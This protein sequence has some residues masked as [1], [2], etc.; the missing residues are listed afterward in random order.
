MR[1]HKQHV[2]IIGAGMGGLASALRLAYAGLRVTVL[3]RLS[4][5]GGKMR[6]LPSVAG[7]VDAGPTVLTM[8]GVFDALFA[9]TG[10]PLEDHVTL[11]REPLLARHFWK[12]GPTLDLMADPDHSIQ[13]VGDAFGM[14]AADEFKAFS[15]KAKALF[16][17]FDAPVMRAPAP[18]N[19]AITQQMLRTPS[20]LAAMSP[21]LSLSGMLKRQFTDPRLA[22]LFG[23]YATYVGGIPDASPALLSLIWHAEAQ[24]VWHVVGGMHRL[25]QAICA[26]AQEFGAEFAF[27]THVKRIEV[28]EGRPCAVHTDARRIACDLVLFNGDP[29]ALYEG[30]LGESARQAIPKKAT[31]PRSLSAAV[32]AFAA[33]AE[34]VDLAAHNVFFCDDPATEFAPLAK[35]EMPGDATLYICAQDRFDGAQPTGTE[36]FEIIQNAPPSR[37]TAPPDPQETIACQTRIFTQLREF[38]LR[39]TPPPGPQDIT[40]PTGF[41]TLFPASN[42]SLYGRSPHGMMAAFARP[43]TRSAIPGLYLVGGGVH[44]GAGV[45]MVTLCAQAAA[46]AILSDLT[47]TSTSQPEDT[48]GGTSTGSAT[49]AP[50]PSR[51]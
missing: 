48:H 20:L 16:D 10:S 19:L 21:H 35:G 32:H 3:D 26:R 50:V 22:Q 47:S 31:Q 38:G 46:A 37:D 24:G 45:P 14:Q 42:G 27:D 39:F 40:M 28:Q 25:A 49:M 18:S 9:E 33:Q 15:T 7:P 51:S 12:N 30:H 11:K 6:S 2:V 43:T 29:R 13:N 36:R 17:A 34:G 1:T 5:P 8:K 41:A 4:A 23:R 44:P